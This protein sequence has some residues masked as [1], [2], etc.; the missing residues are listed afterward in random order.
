MKNLLKISVLALGLAVAMVS[1]KKDDNSSNPN[2]QFANTYTNCYATVMQQ[3]IGPFDVKI[4][5][6]GDNLAM[7]AVIPTADLMGM[8]VPVS[9]L[10]ITKDTVETEGSA[11]AFFGAVKLQSIS[12]PVLGAISF[13]GAGGIPD[14]NDTGHDAMVATTGAFEMNV[15]VTMD[16]SPMEIQISNDN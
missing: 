4:T 5:N 3:T 8:D 1:C 10:I 12:I 9:N 16:G 14:S 13:A 15:T 6:S 7:S 11:S 2:A